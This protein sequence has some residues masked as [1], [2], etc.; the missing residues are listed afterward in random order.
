MSDS[1]GHFVIEVVV[2]HRVKLHLPEV[3]LE[4]LEV[5]LVVLVGVIGVVVWKYEQRSN[6]TCDADLLVPTHVAFIATS[7]ARS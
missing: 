3:I 5:L 1:R 6:M 2:Q 4:D 7:V